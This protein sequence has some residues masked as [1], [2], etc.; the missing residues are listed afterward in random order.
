MK[1]STK[2]LLALSTV[3]AISISGCSAVQGSNTG[4]SSTTKSAAS[5]ATSTSTT[6]TAQTNSDLANLPF[7][8]TKYPQNYTTVNQNV[9]IFVNGFKQTVAAGQKVKTTRAQTYFEGLDDLGRTQSVSAIV[10]Y[11]MM[12]S[13]AS[14]MARFLSFLNT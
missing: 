5:S 14:S 8:L 1:L 6:E 13:H 9:P 4:Q 11:S 3:L 2:W 12:H 10:T 7:D